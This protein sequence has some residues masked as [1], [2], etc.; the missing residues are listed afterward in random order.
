[1]DVPSNFKITDYLSVTLN[2]Y[3]GTVSSFRKNNQY[4]CYINVCPNHPRQI[5]KHIP[6]GIIFRLSI[7]SSNRDI[8]AQNKHEYQVALK[9]A[10]IRLNLFIS[11]GMKQQMYIIGTIEQGKFY[12]LRHLTIWL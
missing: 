6:N 3:N 12:G 7:N 5:F 11:L 1:M 2:L 4:L 8:F 9:T 10:V